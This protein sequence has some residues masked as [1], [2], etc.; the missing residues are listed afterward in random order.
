MRVSDVVAGWHLVR[1]RT[2]GEVRRCW[3]T[4]WE[5]GA[6]AVFDE[7]GCAEGFLG[8]E[9][10]VR[11]DADADAGHEGSAWSLPPKEIPV[12]QG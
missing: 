2:T 6:L 7:H 9:W 11:S 4:P 1:N 12:E 3:L 5:G 8:D 10:E